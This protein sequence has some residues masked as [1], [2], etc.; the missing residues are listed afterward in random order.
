MT[1][2]RVLPPSSTALP[3]PPSGRTGWPWTEKTD[4]TLYDILPRGGWPK[5]SI[6]CPSFQQG[7]FIEETIR[8][9]LLQNYPS[10]EFII[11]DGGSTDGT[12]DILKRYSPLF[13]HWGAQ[14]DRGQSHALNKCC[15]LATGDII[16]WINSDDYYLPGAFAVVGRAYR[17][18]PRSLIYGDWALR[19]NEE[20]ALSFHQEQPAFAFQV[21]VGGRHL[22]SHA[23]FWPR[24]AH[25]RINE[26]LHFTM[27]AELFK[28]L[29]ASGWRLKYVNRPLAVCRSHP[30]SK[31]T[32]M[33][34][35]AR[36]ETA[37]WSK[38]QPWHTAWRWRISRL[39]DRLRR[40]MTR[41]RLH[42]A[43]R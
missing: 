16:G 26:S 24:V 17:A 41:V 13:A 39:V 5:I 9:V 22:P 19:Q 32:R 33:L 2:T 1:L 36:T 18:A 37:A 20:P 10:L 15:D 35:V 3:A 34:D 8:S 29:A 28:R 11:M 42:F 25:Q 6:V 27:D 7:H 30:A 40:A 31:T 12:G 43:S 38:A 4:P 21:A 14:P 23:T